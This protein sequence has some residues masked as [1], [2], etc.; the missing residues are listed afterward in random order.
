MAFGYLA[1][2]LGPIY[3]NDDFYSIN[4]YLS[5]LLNTTSHIQNIILLDRE[6][7]T[8]NDDIKWAI[9]RYG[10]VGT[11]MHFDYDYLNSVSYYYNGFQNPDHAVAIVGWDDN[12]SRNNFKNAPMGDGAWIVRNSWGPSWGN[13]GYFYVSYY[14]S[15]FAEV[16]EATSYTFILND[17]IC[18]NSILSVSIHSDIVES[19]YNCLFLLIGRT[20]FVLNEPEGIQCDQN[21][22]K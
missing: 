21:Q 17:T 16:N 1:S 10:A 11:S 4:D 19:H 18:C 3:E 13:N 14:D 22:N 12:Y 9:L 2:W 15:K 20:G 7:Y 8:D 5:P 6:S